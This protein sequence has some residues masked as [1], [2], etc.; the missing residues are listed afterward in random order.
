MISEPIVIVGPA[1]EPVTLAEVKTFLREDVSDPFNDSQIQFLAQVA[2]EHI[3]GQT[4]R[5]LISQTLRVFADGWP[6]VDPFRL[7]VGPV[8]A[9]SHIHYY[10]TED[11]HYVYP[12]SNY[13]F[14]GNHNPPLI[15]R[16]YMKLWPSETLRPLNPIHIQFVAGYASPMAIPPRLKQAVLMLTATLYRHR[17]T[18]TVGNTS[19]VATL[20]PQHFQNFLDSLKIHA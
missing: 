6:V 14:D 16:K 18:V 17:E 4:N 13:D 10:D 12:A 3:E 15:L 8:S 9:I 19:A 5:R 20:I 2:R 1:Q 11:T 7:P